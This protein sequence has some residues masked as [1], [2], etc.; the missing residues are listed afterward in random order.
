MKEILLV[1]DSVTILMSVGDILKK[2]GLKVTTANSAQQAIQKLNAGAKPAAILTDYN[3]PGMNGVELI[4]EIRKMPTFRFT[5]ILML[6]TESQTATRDEG[7]KAGATAWLVKPV[8]AS[9]LSQVIK[10]VIPGL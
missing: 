9:D 10:K 5:P 1:D 3:M 6:T 4:K 7:R 8:S 2:L